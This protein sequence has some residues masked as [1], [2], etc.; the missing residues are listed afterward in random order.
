MKSSRVRAQSGQTI[1][2]ILALLL[3]FIAMLTWIFGVNRY[4]TRK[5]RVQDGGDAA[6]LAAARTQASGLNLVGELNLI[7]AYMLSTYGESSELLAATQTLEA[8]Q[9][10]LRLTT[11]MQ[12]LVS[13][14]LLAE[15][16]NLDALPM[17]DV[18]L[19]EFGE[20]I[21]LDSYY[22]GAEEDFRQMM[23][24]F[25]RHARQN[26]GMRVFP[27]AGFYSQSSFYSYLTDQ[28]FYEAILAN[29][30]C[31]FWFNAYPFLQRYS[32]RK[33][34]GSL[35]DF[36]MR[37]FFDL[38]LTT[39]IYSLDEVRFLTTADTMGRP[40]RL[41]PRMQG[42]LDALG[43]PRILAHRPADERLT[44][45][46]V[47]VRW[48]TYDPGYWGEW[49]AMQDNNLPLEGTLK[50]KYN[51]AGCNAAVSV[52]KDGAT[53]IAAAKPFGDL[54]DENPIS[55]NFVLGG[56]EDVRLIPVDAA[57]KGIR[58]FDYMWLS[59]VYFHL[60]EYLA[61]GWHMDGCRY[62][63]ALQKW[64]RPSF[65]ATAIEWLSANGRRSCRRKVPPGP[66]PSGGAS[67]AH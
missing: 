38:R 46:V 4:V 10:R 52:T 34:F 8:L 51:Y 11:P 41:Y 53:W 27:L 57:D 14:Q 42:A 22:E 25:L 36:D 64:E 9:E 2:L 55:T 19:E 47:A 5:L 44:Q 40:Q 66:G 29:D 15:K 67:Y 43:H 20:K 60:P 56:F 6:A 39:Q 7:Q 61:H 37:P 1:L 3:V 13:A 26:G 63:N 31:W 50:E 59:H 24:A 48:T 21:I 12:A 35:P 28:D 62:C 49:E 32:S 58:G 23:D 65:R 30:W 33:D 18:F 54:D 17:A 16:N 45:D